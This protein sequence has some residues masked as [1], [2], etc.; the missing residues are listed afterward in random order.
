[1]I[2]VNSIPVLSAKKKMLVPFDV[3]FLK[4]FRP[5]VKRSW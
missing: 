3:N 5:N 2:L 1:M 4:N